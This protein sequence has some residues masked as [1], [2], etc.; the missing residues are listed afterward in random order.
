MRLWLL[1]RSSLSP[2]Q[3]SLQAAG[4]QQPTT[5]CLGRLGPSAMTA[6]SCAWPASGPCSMLKASMVVHGISCHFPSAKRRRF[7]EP[8]CWVRLQVPVL[9]NAQMQACAGGAA[10]SMQLWTRNYVL[11]SGTAS[12]SS[13]A[14]V[15]VECKPGYACH[16]ASPSHITTNISCGFCRGTPAAKCSSSCLH[17]MAE[18]ACPL[19]HRRWMCS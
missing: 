15:L 6:T 11:S 9:N 12:I 14:Q 2:T 18:A 3:S 13:M 7:A 8:L 1:R 16:V 4:T 5:A 19:L 10:G 17:M